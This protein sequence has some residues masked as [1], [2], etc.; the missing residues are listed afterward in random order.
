MVFVVQRE[1]AV[2]SASEQAEAF[3]IRST[4]FVPSA[5]L[6]TKTLKP[7]EYGGR[8]GSLDAVVSWLRWIST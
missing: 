4:P 8:L 5:H 7:A 1:V 6:K 3:V 2:G